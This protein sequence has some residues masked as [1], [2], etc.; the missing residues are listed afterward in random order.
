MTPTAAWVVTGAARQAHS[1]SLCYPR[2]AWCG[3]VADTASWTPAPAD[4]PRCVRC[5]RHVD[6]TC[7]EAV[8][9]A[10]GAT[11][12]KIDYWCRIGCLHPV[13]YFPGS[14]SLRTWPP[15]EVEVARRMVELTAAGLT[16][17]AAHHAARNDGRLPGGALR[18]V[19]TEEST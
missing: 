15:E 13:Q 12:R 5:A 7:A 17:E 1:P 11:Y 19:P 10:T 8:V 6:R 4:L 14:G 16:V 9:E 3:A 18:V 2:R